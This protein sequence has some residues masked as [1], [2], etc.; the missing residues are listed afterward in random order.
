MAER[1]Q[2]R[3]DDASR[4]PLAPLE[5]RTLHAQV[6]DR[7]RDLITEGRLTPGEKLNEVQVCAELGVSRTPFREAL[8]TLAGEGLIETHSGRSATVR[9][10]SPEEVQGMLEVMAEIEALAGRLACERASNAEIA[11]IHAVHAEMLDLYARR[12]R[13]AYYKLNQRIHTMIAAVSRNPTL[14]ELHANLQ[15][16]MK[17]IRFIGHNAPENWHNAVTE[18]QAM[19]EALARRDGDALAAILRGHLLNTWQRVRGAL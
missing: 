6:V 11:A 14:V 13:L 18:H 5:R 1:E 2:P 3:F 17:R 7:L 19:D 8:K 12:E 10:Y 4:T 16:R 15:A 9:S